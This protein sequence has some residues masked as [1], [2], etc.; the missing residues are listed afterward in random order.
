[1]MDYVTPL[2]NHLCSLYIFTLRGY[3]FSPLNASGQKL[4]LKSW[5]SFVVPFVYGG[6]SQHCK[7]ESVQCWLH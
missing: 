4:D 3:I 6:V 2:T 5:P 1:M 7:E